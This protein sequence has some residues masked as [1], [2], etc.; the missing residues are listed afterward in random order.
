M[1][2]RRNYERK[3]SALTHSF[4]KYEVT[5]E[6][7]CG[8]AGKKVAYCDHNCGMTD[9]K[10]IAAL[11]HKDDNGDYKCDNGCGHEFEKPAPE[12][13]TPDTPDEPT[14]N[15]C[16]HLCHKSGIMGFFCKIIKFFSKLFKINPV[17]ECG[18][19]HY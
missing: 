16:N 11:T 3:N 12:E 2:Y 5:E 13:P 14:D 17:C 9:E 10:V 19:T 15:A 8:V 18:A 1:I 6:A 7:K 4:T